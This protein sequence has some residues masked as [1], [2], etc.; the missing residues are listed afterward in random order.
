M[1]NQFVGKHVSVYWE[2]QAAWF[3]GIVTKYDPATRQH[4]TLYGLG[5]DNVEVAWEALHELPPALITVRGPASAEAFAQAVLFEEEEPAPDQG[6]AAVALTLSELTMEQLEAEVDRTNSYDAVTNIE[7]EYAA[8]QADLKARLE[9]L[10][11]EELSE[12]E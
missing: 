3:E 10:D 4:C 8:R 6:G 1:D 11:A 5:T 12:L 7:A 9:V 2:E